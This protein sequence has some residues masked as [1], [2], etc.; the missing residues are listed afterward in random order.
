MWN[1]VEYYVEFVGSSNP[2]F[3]SKFVR[4]LGKGE[5]NVFGEVG[6]VGYGGRREERKL[7][8]ERSLFSLPS[9][10]AW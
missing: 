1:T 6:G 3:R 10:P 5:G 7:G 9:S 4:S 8:S 2:W